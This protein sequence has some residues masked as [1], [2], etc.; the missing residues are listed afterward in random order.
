[1]TGA[2]TPS[3]TRQVPGNLIT[4]SL[5]NTQAGALAKWVFGLPMFVGRNN[6]GQSIANT[7]LTPIAWDT[8]D[9]DT[10]GAHTTARPTR[11][12]APTAGWYA[13][14]GQIDYSANNAGQRNII[15]LVNGATHLAKMETAAVNGFDTAVST[16]ADVF[17]AAG[18]YLELCAWH[19]AGTAL[20]IN[21]ADGNARFTARWVHT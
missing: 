4:G 10:H 1:V 12:T 21:A 6:A 11:F 15:L 9:L 20:T 14:T 2:A 13:A 7:T 17:L 18:D 19:N 16:T 5:W 3:F 8:V